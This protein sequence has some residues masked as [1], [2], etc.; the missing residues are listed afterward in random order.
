MLRYITLSLLLLSPVAHAEWRP[1]TQEDP[2]TDVVSKGA[3]AISENIQDNRRA[4]IVAFCVSGK[5]KAYVTDI[6][7]F[8]GPEAYDVMWRIDKK[9]PVSEKWRTASSND[10]LWFNDFLHMID[11]FKT[12]DKYIIRAS[13]DFAG[14]VDYE[15]SLTGFSDAFSE[16]LDQCKDE[17]EKYSIRKKERVKRIAEARVPNPEYVQN[18]IEKFSGKRIIFWDKKYEFVGVTNSKVVSTCENMKFDDL[19]KECTRLVFKSLRHGIERHYSL[20]E[21]EASSKFRILN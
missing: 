9:K 10:T 18:I 17:Y 11:E 8:P 15:F 16:P 1:F 4:A 2:M 6:G 14:H 21:L 7:Y 13:R 5:L 19:S 3:I 20:E 12:G